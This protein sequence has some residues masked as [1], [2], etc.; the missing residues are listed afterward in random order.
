MSDWT[1]A[2]AAKWW[3]QSMTIR[4]VLITAATTVLPALA[5]AAG[6]DVGLVRVLGEQAI[7]VAQSIG[8]LIGT[9]MAIAGRIR[10]DVPVTTRDVTIRL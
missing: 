5:A 1:S 7:G 3:G 9:G 10:A 8:G 6:V 4:G 2:P